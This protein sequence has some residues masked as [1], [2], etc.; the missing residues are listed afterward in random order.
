MSDNQFYIDYNLIPDSDLLEYPLQ[1][2]MIEFNRDKILAASVDII[3]GNDESEYSPFSPLSIFYHSDWYDKPVE[4]YN[5]RYGLYTFKGRIKNITE[6]SK[7]K[8]VTVRGTNFVRD[9]ADS[10]LNWSSTAELTPAELIL[11]ILTDH[12]GIDE[13]Y[14]NQGSFLNV[15]NVQDADSIYA[16][17]NY[18]TEDNISC[19][20][21]IEELCRITNCH[22]Y[23]INNIIYLWSWEEYSGALGT[24]II[25]KDIDPGSFSTTFVDKVVNA[26]KIA[27]KNGAS[28]AYKTTDYPTSLTASIAKFGTRTFSVPNEN[29]ESTT[30]T[31]FKILLQS[32]AAAQWCGNRQIDRYADLTQTFQLTLDG[33]LSFLHLNDQ[34]DLDF[35]NFHM[36]PGRITAIKPDRSRNQIE[37]DGEFLNLPVNVVTRDEEPPISPEL[38]AA[39][40][41]RK[42][43]LLKWT[44]NQE[45]DLAGYYIYLS[46]TKGMWYQ[47][48][49]HLGRSPIEIK[50]PAI[51]ADGYCYVEIRELH[52]GTIYYFKI[53]AFDTS[54]NEGQ[55][56]NILCAVPPLD[57]DNLGNWLYLDGNEFSSIYLDSSN[58]RE[59]EAPDGFAVFDE[60]IFDTDV[61]APAGIW[62]S[63]V[64]FSPTGWERIYWKGYTEGEGIYCQIKTSDDNVTWTSWGSEIDAIVSSSLAIGGYK[65]FQIRFLFYSND[66]SDTD[67]V[68]ITNMEVT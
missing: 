31:D 21:V 61:F 68:Y 39:M 27:Y 32:A 55:A 62:E 26:Y 38:I 46:A 52:P 45:T 23:T 10:I 16:D 3:L 64:Y 29:I 30:A 58:P 14:I 2:E 25:P 59:G 1:E 36:E 24:R 51:S 33:D 37:I 17:L 34:V 35:G 67:W 65:Y 7:R 44:A 48:L 11:T 19:L 8:T 56:S 18:S 43:V 60:A 54:Y 20:A 49:C 53:S 40:P 47:E 63:P 15:I 13:E 57:V 66:W 9:M 42:K 5:S 4:I 6:D 41:G 28:V 22:L 12:V 50:N